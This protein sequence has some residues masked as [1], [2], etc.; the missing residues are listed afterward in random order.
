[1]TDKNQSDLMYACDIITKNTVIN[2]YK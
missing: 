1:M 2:N